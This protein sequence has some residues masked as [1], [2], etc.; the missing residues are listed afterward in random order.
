MTGNPSLNL[1]VYT[2]VIVEPDG[3]FDQQL[4]SIPSLDGSRGS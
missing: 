4:L 1:T 2:G 3:D